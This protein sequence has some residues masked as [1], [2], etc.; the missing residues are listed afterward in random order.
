[1]EKEKRIDLFN[2]NK[3][4][5]LAFVRGGAQELSPS[6]L[7]TVVYEDDG[8]DKGPFGFG[9][10]RYIDCWTGDVRKDFSAF[11][12]VFLGTSTSSY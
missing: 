9:R 3:L 2:E 7:A 5:N 4:Q 1:M 10:T 11:G 6:E 8:D 12:I